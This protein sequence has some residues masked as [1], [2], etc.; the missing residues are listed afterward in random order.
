MYMYVVNSVSCFFPVF[1]SGMMVGAGLL[2]ASSTTHSSSYSA[3]QDHPT[4]EETWQVRLDQFLWSMGLLYF[5]QWEH[6]A[7]ELDLCTFVFRQ[8]N[9][10]VEISPSSLD[11][12]KMA[13]L[14]E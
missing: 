2:A 12:P 6:A 7:I 1:I 4:I 14:S 11:P 3:T 8:C 9:K 13:L 10:G 5:V